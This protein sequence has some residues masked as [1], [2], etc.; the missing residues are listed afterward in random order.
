MVNSERLL[1]LKAKGQENC[2]MIADCI[3]NLLKTVTFTAFNHV[4][5]NRVATGKIL[6]FFFSFKMF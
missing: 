6:N 3:N 4:P 5:G 2:S 1:I